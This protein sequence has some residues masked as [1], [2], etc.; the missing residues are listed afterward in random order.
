MEYSKQEAEQIPEDFWV[1][2]KTSSKGQQIISINSS[3]EDSVRAA[4]FAYCIEYGKGP[5]LKNL[6]TSIPLH[7]TRAEMLRCFYGVEGLEEIE[8]KFRENTEVVEEQTVWRI[9]FSS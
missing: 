4:A 3:N 9:V 7:L 1:V 2:T 6:A 5:L 8:R